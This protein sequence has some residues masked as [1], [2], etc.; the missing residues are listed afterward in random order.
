[1]ALIEV[2]TFQYAAYLLIF[3]CNISIAE[4]EPFYV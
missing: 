4:F 2:G 1:M 3:T